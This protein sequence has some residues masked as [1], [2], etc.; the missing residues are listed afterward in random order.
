MKKREKIQITHIR[1]ER[2]AIST[3]LLNIKR[4]INIMKILCP[5][6]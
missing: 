2:G 1:N 6:I 3:D 5:Q 4:I